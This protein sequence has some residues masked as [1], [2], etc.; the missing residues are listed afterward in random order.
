MHNIKTERIIQHSTIV[1]QIETR[2]DHP[3]SLR[4]LYAA[5]SASVA[6]FACAGAII[7]DEFNQQKLGDPFVSGF[8]AGMFAAGSIL[9][10]RKYYTEFRKVI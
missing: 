10:V 3:A 8:A 5:F 4:P 7:A 2:P 1:P 9:S 6:S